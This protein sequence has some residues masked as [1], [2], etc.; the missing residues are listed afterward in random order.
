MNAD[1]LNP[2][3]LIIIAIYDSVLHGLLHCTHSK[4]ISILKYVSWIKH[5]ALDLSVIVAT[6]DGME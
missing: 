1:T 2:S 6:A 4:L 5:D 3:M